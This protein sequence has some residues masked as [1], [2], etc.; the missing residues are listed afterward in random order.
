MISKPMMYRVTMNVKYQIS[1]I[2]IIGYP[3]SFKILFKQTSGSAIM[4][5]DCFGITVKQI[6]KCMRRLVLK[7]H[8]KHFHVFYA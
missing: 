7:F 8:R 5:V 3:Y 2:V 1:E 4:L 6:G